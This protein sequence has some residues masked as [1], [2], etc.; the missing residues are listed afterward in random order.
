M[1]QENFEQ[2]AIVDNQETATKKK[3][4]LGTAGL[5]LGIIGTATAFIPIVNNASF[6][7][8]ILAVVFG[9]IGLVKHLGKGK[10]I[11]ALVL[12]IAAI[13][14]TISA[15]EQ[16]S[17]EL[18]Y[19]TGERTEDI[20]Q[21]YLTVEIGKFEVHED[22]YWTDTEVSVT[23]KNKGKEKKSFSITIEAV[24]AKGARINTD[25]IYANDLSAGQSQVFKVFDYVASNDIEAY[26][27]ASFR[28]VEVSMY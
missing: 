25:T 12:G 17:K 15:Q 24:D 2:E 18:D 6:V 27:K 16:T 7:L 23:I 10:A 1:T 13:V 19:L 21:N 28:V 14:I 22:E 4:L 9:I 11:A 3:S 5:I 8:G 26:K 20:L